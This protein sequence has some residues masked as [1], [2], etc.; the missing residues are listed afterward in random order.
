LALFTKQAQNGCEKTHFANLFRQQNNASFHLL[1]IG[2]VPLE[3]KTLIGMVTNSFRAEFQNFPE[4]GHLPQ[5]PDFRFF[6]GTLLV[7]VL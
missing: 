5:K 1:P 7:H 3:H 2:Q 6:W 4:R